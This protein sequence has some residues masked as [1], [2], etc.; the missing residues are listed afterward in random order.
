MS[1]DSA[2]PMPTPS[3]YRTLRYTPIS[4]LLHGRLSGRLDLERAIADYGL[5]AGPRGLVLETARRTRLWNSERVLVARELAAHFQD[6]LASGAAPDDLV[7]SFGDPRQAASLIRRAKKRNRPPAWKALVLAVSLVNGALLLLVLLYAYFLMRTLVGKPNIVRNFSAELNSA[8]AAIPESERAWPLYR[9]AALKTTPWPKRHPEAVTPEDPNWPQVV[10]LV[11]S[12]AEPI[13]LYHQGAARAALGAP[14]GFE[15][16]LELEYRHSPERLAQ[17]KAV[18]Q[19]N[20]DENPFVMGILLPSL[21]SLREGAKLLALDARVAAQS[22]DA[23]RAM[24]DARTLLRLSDHVANENFLICD[25]VSLSIGAMGFNLVGEVIDRRPDLLGEPQLVEL[26]HRIAALRG[27]GTFHVSYRGERV[28]F[29]DF[30]Q[31]VYTDDGHGGGH[32]TREGF[33]LITSITSG[34]PEPEWSTAARFAFAPVFGAV[35]AD[36]NEMWRH[37]RELMD[38]AD[39][40]A[41]IP[42]WKRGASAADQMLVELTSSRFAKFR[43]FP[44]AV[45]VPSLSAAAHHAEYATQ[46]RDAA[47]VVLAANLHRLRSGAWPQT[48]A[49]LS[50]RYLPTVPPDRYDGRP[51]K[52][53][54]RDGRPVVYSVGVD[55]DDDGGV[56]PIGK[57][58]NQRARRFVPAD[59]LAGGT[60]SYLF[61][62]DV[63]G[64]WVLWPAPR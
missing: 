52:Y 12:N 40:D 64:D 32:L 3:L 47:L 39:A 21:A 22:G 26:S 43:Y 48:I 56:P 49:E 41:Q 58:G 33:E 13:R 44:L 34:T 45:L 27:G 17:A 28:F 6:G 54:F 15:P 9:E 29:E 24:N 7:S 63:N 5:P 18:Q 23:E 59:T 36:R 14:I 11:E 53:V 19:P 8:I 20:T 55:R 2:Q 50:P 61:N 42:L 62:G 60:T 1:T 51:I 4:D 37:W 16:D 31:R 57:D 30:L 46:Q 38:A 10:K 25:L 35:L